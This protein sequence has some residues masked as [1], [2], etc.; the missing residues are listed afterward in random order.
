[1]NNGLIGYPQ[2]SAVSTTTV[3]ST[4]TARVG[5]T[6]SGSWT[7]PAG[8][9]RA[10]I[11]INTAGAGGCGGDTTLSGAGG[12]GG[13]YLCLAVDVT[14]AEVLTLTLG[15]GGAGG[16][17]VNGLGVK[18]GDASITR[19]NG[20]LVAWVSG[21]LSSAPVGSYI[22]PPVN[23]DVYVANGTVIA[24]KKGG[25]G[26]RGHATVN[27]YGGGGGGGAGWGMGW[28]IEATD[29]TPASDVDVSVVGVGGMGSTGALGAHTANA[30]VAP[31]LALSPESGSG[32]RATGGA[33]AH[34]G[35][36]AGGSGAS[37]GTNGGAGGAG[38]IM[39]EY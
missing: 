39:M 11:H 36:G 15:S 27:G 33:G 3:G 2:R 30:G 16:S 28:G 29:G 9:T 19:S 12:N 35:R 32:A 18:G 1:M 21:G 8:V 4:S 17:G 24:Y 26:G 13:N 22:R 31:P 37:T 7:V 38:Y 23:T 14:P 6:S 5:F 34:G 25:R 10:T 20:N